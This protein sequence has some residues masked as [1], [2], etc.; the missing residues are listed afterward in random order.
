M[1]TTKIWIYPQI[2][3]EFV[4]CSLWVRLFILPIEEVESHRLTFTF[5]TVI[6]SALNKSLVI[7]TIISNGLTRI[8]PRFQTSINNLF[9]H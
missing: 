1:F 2:Q 7:H 3:E 8:R 4:G 9:Y 6:T 5:P